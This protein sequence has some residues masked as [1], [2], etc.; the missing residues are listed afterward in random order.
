[1]LPRTQHFTLVINLLYI[2]PPLLNMCAEMRIVMEKVDL[3]VHSTYSDGT[4]TPKELIE[5]AEKEGLS[6]IALTDHDTLDGIP[7]ALAASDKSPVE[8]IPG[9]ELSTNFDRTEVH[10]VGLFLD[11]TNNEI[12]NYLARQRQSRIDRNIQM[13]QKFCDIGINITYDKMCELYPDAVI[14]RAHFADY[15]VKNKYTG[16]RNEAFDRYLSPGKPCYVSRHKVD[17]KD[18]VNI[19]HAAHGVAVLAHPVLYHLGK[20]QMNALLDNVCN[21]G[22]DGIEAIY[23]TYKPAD[24]RYIRTLAKEHNLLISGGS[25]YHGDNKPHIQ[26]GRGMGHL[27]VPSEVLDNLRKRSLSYK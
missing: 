1:M 11:Y 22:I 8:L 20:E 17:P 5:I 16:D 18:A 9:V 23:S 21:A 3:H 13:C 27:F 15:L 14:T 4:K 6:A 10:I 24:E 19:I 7:A 12:N 2:R 25:D 26:L